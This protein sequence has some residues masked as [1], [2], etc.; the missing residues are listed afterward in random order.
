MP[1]HFESLDH[2]ESDVYSLRHLIQE[3][4]R[5]LQNNPMDPSLILTLFDKYHAD[6][7]KPYALFDPTQ[8]YTRNLVDDGNGKFNIMILAWTEGQYS[9]IHNHSGSHCIMKI[10]EGHLQESLYDWPEKDGQPL[11]LLQQT[12]LLPNQT[13]YVHDNIGLH[14]ITNPNPNRGAVSLHLY[15]PPYQTCTTFQERTGQA[16][17]SGICTFHSIHGKPT[18]F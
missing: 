10:L 13:T 8:P 16:V 7:W 4:H 6:D 3:I 9:P 18:S 15:T 17:Q 5:V 1:P 12:L 11:T 2:Q 14:R